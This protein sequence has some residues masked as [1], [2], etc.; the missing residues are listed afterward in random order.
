MRAEFASILAL[1]AGAAACTSEPR[2]LIL[3]APAEPLFVAAVMIEDG[4]VAAASGL[5]R[6]DPGEGLPVFVDNAE[7]HALLGFSA[8]DLAG[9]SLPDETRLSITPLVAAQGCEPPL[10]AASWRARWPVG[11]AGP[12]PWPDAIDPPRLTVAWL[13]DQCEAVADPRWMVETSCND[14]GVFA[15]VNPT[16]NRCVREL[17]LAN[18]QLPTL[19]A[20]LWY[21][22]RVCAEPAEPSSTCARAAENPSSVSCAG[23]EPCVLSV[24]LTELE[25]APFASRI[26]RLYPELENEPD[27]RF[28]AT[29]EYRALRTKFGHLRS[30]VVLPD[31]IWVAGRPQPIGDCPPALE[32]GIPDTGEGMELLQVSRADLV[33]VRTAT[34][35]ACLG[36]LLPGLSGGFLG[37]FVGDGGSWIARFDGHGRIE[38]RRRLGSGS[39]DLVW[40]NQRLRPE[41][42]LRTAG[43][44]LALAM[45]N[46]I[47]RPLDADTSQIVL[48]DETSLEETGRISSAVAGRITWMEP[49]ES[50]RVALAFHSSN[51]IQF[52]DLDQGVLEGRIN[53]EHDPGQGTHG[54]AYRAPLL[55]LAAQNLFFLFDPS[56]QREVYRGAVS[57]RPMTHVRAVPWPADPNLLLVL[58]M[59]PRSSSP[60]V[61]LATFFDLEQRQFLPSAFETGAYGV[62][63]QV[64][65]D[66]A[67]GFYLLH[68]WSS[69][70]VHL[71][72]KNP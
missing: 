28:V 52:A 31:R 53:F 67:G 49:L 63:H 69:E 54:L 16:D 66:G 8:S 27:G 9:L 64:V 34:A 20:R 32:S 11:A 62:A 6:W 68:P 7:E 30:M 13:G 37:T 3:D 65:S 48:L 59:P 2:P 26:V 58:G 22:G 56:N 36:N 38:R 61:A 43:G 12:E 10:P 33:L 41:V 19:R 44:R 18:Y 42:L 51:V 47:D 17:T 40:D 46:E 57:A 21:D 39:G 4:R 55:A 60:Y 71:T 45:T 1:A 5:V 50:G 70:L 14:F 24:G 72:P 23:N 25:E 15:T 29:R 35:P